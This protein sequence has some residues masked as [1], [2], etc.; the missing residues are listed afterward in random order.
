MAKDL[1]VKDLEKIA[2][3]MGN[4]RRL[5]ILRLLKSRSMNVQQISEKLKLSF[6]STSRHL[7][8][9]KSVGLVDTRKTS[10]QVFYYLNR[11]T[12]SVVKIFLDYL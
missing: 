7:G 4:E 10:L 2:K 12:H 3:A 1:L 5:I 11:P 6:K 8:V 9:L